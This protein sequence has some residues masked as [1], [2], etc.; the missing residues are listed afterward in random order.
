M[1]AEESISRTLELPAWSVSALGGG[2]VVDRTRDGVDREGRDT[3]MREEGR[4]GRGPR[5]GESCSHRGRM[6][7]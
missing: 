5:R 2:E 4:V 6:C 7:S 3:L 1:G